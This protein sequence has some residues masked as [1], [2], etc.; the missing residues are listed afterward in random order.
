MGGIY[1]T[2]RGKGITACT[3]LVEKHE[4]KRPLGKPRYRWEII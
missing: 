3:V 2:N 1:N 4:R